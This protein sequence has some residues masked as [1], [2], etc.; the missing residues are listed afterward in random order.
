MTNTGRPIAFW[1]I[2]VFFV[3]SIVGLLMVQTLSVFY[4]DTAV[5][6]GFQEDA[7]TISEFGVQFNRA[8]GVADTLIYVPLLVFSL[9]GLFMRKRWSLITTGAV[10]AISAYW[11]LVIGSML[12]FVP[13]VPGYN[14]YPGLGHWSFLGIH[15]VIGAWGVIYV[16]FRGDDLI[17]N[18]EQ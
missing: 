9:I 17:Q 7:K 15:V 16:V 2:V 1:I 4:Y 13:G 8:F 10:M 18:L 5:K 11:P 3:G 6:L 14:F 12:L